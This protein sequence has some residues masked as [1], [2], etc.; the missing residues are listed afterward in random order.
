MS[1][2]LVWTQKYAT[3]VDTI[4]G[5]HQTL[6]MMVNALH[7]TLDHDDASEQLPGLFRHL[8]EYVDTHF[9][10]EEA[11]MEEHDYPLLDEHRDKHRQLA[12]TLESMVAEFEK[13]PATFPVDD[14]M[15]FLKNWLTTHVLKS[16]MDYVPFVKP[17]GKLGA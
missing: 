17:D 3:G 1:D 8:M 13:A 14:L 16:D 6:F 10:R 11:L 5:D 9:R 2:F 15:D 12:A 4:D 7:D